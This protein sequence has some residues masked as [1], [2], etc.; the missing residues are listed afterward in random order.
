MSTLSPDQHDLYLEVL[1]AAKRLY[2]GDHD[3]AMRWMSQPVISLN[4]P[5]GS[6]RSVC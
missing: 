3:A 4:D 5:A 1:K 6:G 2:S